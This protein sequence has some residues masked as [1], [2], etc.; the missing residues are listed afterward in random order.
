MHIHAHRPSHTELQGASWWKMLYNYFAWAIW[1]SQLPKPSWLANWLW[2]GTQSNT[3]HA[4]VPFWQIFAD[5]QGFVWCVIK[6]QNLQHL[7]APLKKTWI[8]SSLQYSVFQQFHLLRESISI[9]I[10]AFI[11]QASITKRGVRKAS[12]DEIPLALP[13][14]HHSLA[15]S[16]RFLMLLL[17]LR[18]RLDMGLLRPSHLQ[19]RST[20]YYECSA[21]IFDSF[22][23]NNNQSP[24]SLALC[25]LYLKLWPNFKPLV[26]ASWARPKAELTFVGKHICRN[27]VFSSPILHFY[28]HFSPT[29]KQFSF[30]F[31]IF[32]KESAHLFSC[33]NLSQSLS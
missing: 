15:S 2:I 23:S 1:K 12:L 22:C 11:E 6:R 33:E 16:S 17:L 25:V 30:G 9:L 13:K 19:A 10:K 14:L 24:F 18:A 5:F 21:R 27:Q 31:D 32:K 4:T 26:W 20:N 28:T 7:I 3:A 29:I 8:A